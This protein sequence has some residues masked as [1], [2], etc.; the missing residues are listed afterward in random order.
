M[1]IGKTLQKLREKHD[2]TQEGLAHELGIS[3]SAYSKIENNTASIKFE[4]LL[5]LSKILN[6]DIKDLLVNDIEKQVENSK[7]INK[8]IIDSM[9]ALQNIYESRIKHL[10]EEVLFLRDELKSKRK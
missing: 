10:E 6:F 2:F 7:Q 1:K 4:M 5:N 9:K 3:Q 8:P